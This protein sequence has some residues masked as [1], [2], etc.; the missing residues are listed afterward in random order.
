MRITRATCPPSTASL[1][2]KTSKRATSSTAASI[3][4]QAQFT[5]RVQQGELLQLLVGGQQIAFDPVGKE[6]QRAL[7]R[8]RPR[9]TRW[10]WAARRWAIHCGSARRSTGSTRTVAPAAVQGQ[11][12]GAGQL[13]LVELGQGDEGHHVLGQALAIALQGLGAVLAG[14]AAEGCGSR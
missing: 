11:E 1:S 10:P 12:P 5:G 14:L 3:C 7:A 2:L 8:S 4:S 13:G 6:G 9:S